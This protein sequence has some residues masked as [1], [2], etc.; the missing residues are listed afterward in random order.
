MK[1]KVAGLLALVLL[2]TCLLWGCGGKKTYIIAT[3]PAYAPFEYQEGDTL[4]GLDIELLQ[5]IAKKGRFSYEVKVLGAAAGL[6]ALSAGEVD[7]VIAGI[8]MTEENKARYEFAD[9]Y[10]DT[11]IVLAVARDNSAI[12]GYNALFGKTVAVKTGTA[13]AAFAE[14]VREQ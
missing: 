1:R 12:T 8:P 3:D 6:Q 11:G 4:K 13:A 7:A 10:F 9:P 2:A 5:A 14:T